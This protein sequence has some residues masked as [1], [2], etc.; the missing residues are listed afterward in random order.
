KRTHTHHPL[1][2]FPTRRS[3]DLFKKI[4]AAE[5]E[6]FKRD[7]VRLH[8][9][10]SVE[11]ITDAEILREVVNT[12][13]QHGRLGEHVRCVVNTALTVQTEDRKSTRLNSSHG[14]I[15]YAVF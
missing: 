2:S 5:I 8:G 10:G 7:Y 11:N 12:V 14:S 1:Y 3:S 15:S 13:G 9:Q 4:F 6:A